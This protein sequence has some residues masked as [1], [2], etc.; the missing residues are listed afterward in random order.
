MSILTEYHSPQCRGSLNLCRSDSCCQY[1]WTHFFINFSKALIIL[2]GW[3][4]GPVMP[5]NSQYLQSFFV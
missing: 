3:I 5:S 2:R 4:L 1:V